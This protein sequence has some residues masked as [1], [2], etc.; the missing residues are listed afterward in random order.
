[1]KRVEKTLKVASTKK[2]EVS[3]KEMPDYRMNTLARQT[4]HAVE[5]FFA[6][7][8]IQEDYEKWLKECKKKKE[9]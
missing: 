4:F 5:R 7:P 2:V 1:M 9:A 6:L 8:G 3:T